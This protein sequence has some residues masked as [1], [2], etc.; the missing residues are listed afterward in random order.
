MDETQKD[1]SKQENL[2][3]KLKQ[4]REKIERLQ[5]EADFIELAIQRE[6]LKEKSKRSSNL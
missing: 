4:L 5:K 3:L 1:R 6:Q 2:E